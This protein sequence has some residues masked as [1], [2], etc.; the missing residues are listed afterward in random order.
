[1]GVVVV[2]P[3]VVPVVVLRVFSAAGVAVVAVVSPGVAFVLNGNK[4]ATPALFTERDLS[5]RQDETPSTN[6]RSQS[7]AVL[8]TART[9]KRTRRPNKH[10]TQTL[11]E[12]AKSSKTNAT[13][14]ARSGTIRRLRMSGQT[15]IPID[16]TAT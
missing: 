8:M 14:A 7:H 4:S 6:V 15:N 11:T 9:T 12:N 2:V 16:D 10:C 1:M 5:K 13:Q 3:V